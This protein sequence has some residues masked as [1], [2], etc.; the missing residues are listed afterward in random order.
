MDIVCICCD[1]VWPML[2]SWARLQESDL[3]DW[4]M[5]SACRK[6]SSYKSNWAFFFLYVYFPKYAVIIF[7]GFFLKI[8]LSL[9]YKTTTY[10]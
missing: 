2:Y 7:T 6:Y 3:H 10:N 4:V 9:F 8:I 5:P 1:S